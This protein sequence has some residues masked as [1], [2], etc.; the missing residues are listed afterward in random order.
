MNRLDFLLVIAFMTV[1][2]LLM[3]GCSNPMDN[4]TGN[5]PANLVNTTWSRQIGT[6]TAM[7]SFGKNG[8]TVSGTKTQWDGYCPYGSIEN[9]TGCCGFR[10]TNG[11]VFDWQ[12]T[13][14]GNTLNV[15]NCTNSSFNGNWTKVQ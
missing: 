11:V 8:V 3:A 9:G 7:L 12:Y 10:N 15:W 13:C 4:S 5:V 6:N 1:G 14:I 2:L